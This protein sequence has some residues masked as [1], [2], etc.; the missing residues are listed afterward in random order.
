[1]NTYKI[2]VVSLLTL[3]QTA[4]PSRIKSQQ[5]LPH[6][7]PSLLYPSNNYIN[8]RTVTQFTIGLLANGLSKNSYKHKLIANGI[9]LTCGLAAHVFLNKTVDQAE[10]RG[11][12]SPAEEQRASFKSSFTNNLKSS[13]ASY[14]VGAG[15]GAL[16][17]ALFDTAKQWICGNENLATV[18]SILGKDYHKPAVQSG[19][20]H[21]VSDYEVYRMYRGKKNTMKALLRLECTEHSS[22]GYSRVTHTAWKNYIEK[23]LATIMVDDGMFVLY[24]SKVSMFKRSFDAWKNFVV[25]SL[26]KAML[27]IHKSELTGVIS[28]ETVAKLQ[29]NKTVVDA[30]I[31]KIMD[32][33]K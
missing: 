20:T 19:T 17:R 30:A 13:V 5:E 9:G 15:T 7:R 21:S 29:H 3:V 1:M 27:L 24:D 16:S 33:I 23:D 18:Q 12:I 26:Q 28:Q 32:A 31:K 22:C 25:E 4:H 11:I 14:G 10:Y 2:I 6:Y 8:A